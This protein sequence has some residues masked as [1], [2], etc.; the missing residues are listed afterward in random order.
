VIF[1]GSQRGNPG[2]PN[3]GGG[4]GGGPAWENAQGV[5]GSEGGSGIVVV[6]YRRNS[7][8]QTA[9][10]ATRTS[11][12]PLNTSNDN[13]GTRD[14]RSAQSNLVIDYDFS[15]PSSY[16]YPG[17]GTTVTDLTGN[18]YNGTL[19]T[20]AVYQGTNY[21]VIELD[22]IGEVDA[23]PPGGYIAVPSAPTVTTT[24]NYPNG[25]T[26][27]IWLKVDTDADD[28]L[29]LFFGAGTI[30]HI[31]IYSS[32]R[33]FR[34]EAATQN[35]K[36]FSSGTFPEPCRGRWSNFTIV[37]SN[38][39]TN[40]PVRWYQNGKLFGT[41]FMGNGNNP[42][43]EYFSFS[44]I[45]RATGSATYLYARSFNGNIGSFS[46]YNRTLSENEIQNNFNITRDRFGI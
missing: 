35:G 26:Y 33:Y 23:D 31:E 42:T 6:R 27:D 45:G 41:G 21:G 44:A 10:T 22:G 29:S 13:S 38:T 20:G 7:S 43:G 12:L 2:A 36:S 18:G 37:F 24:A 25:C 28:R 1:A 4:G 5:Q 46:L 32:S 39:E 8:I 40:R 14:L 3:T 16:S 9:P 34:T 17:S 15:N 19:A 30:N 11:A